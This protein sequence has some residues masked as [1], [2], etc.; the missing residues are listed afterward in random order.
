MCKSCKGQ[1][2]EGDE[3]CAF[4]GGELD[5]GFSDEDSIEWGRF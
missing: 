2:F 1:R 3:V 4:C 5:E